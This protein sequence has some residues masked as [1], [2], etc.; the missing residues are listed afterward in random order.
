M[1]VEDRMK[2]NHE[3]AAAKQELMAT[4][5]ELMA[6]KQEQVEAKV[7]EL[8]EKMATEMATEMWRPTRPG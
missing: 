5:Q 6:A 2:E 4:K 7:G 3:A 8:S 1:K